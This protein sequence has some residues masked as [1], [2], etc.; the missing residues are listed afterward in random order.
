[1]VSKQYINTAYVG[2]QMRA[3]EKN[4]VENRAWVV[5]FSQLC[6]GYSVHLRCT[7]VETEV[8]RGLSDLS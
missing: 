3:T 5:V 8:Q 6:G 4:E 2:G 7:D 1:M